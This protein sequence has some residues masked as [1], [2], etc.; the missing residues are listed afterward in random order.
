LAIKRQLKAAWK[1]GNVAKHS[2]EVEA[3]IKLP[4]KLIEENVESNRLF[5][6]FG[7]FCFQELI[8]PWCFV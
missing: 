3:E 8:V 7:S 6:G 2:P 1:F 4:A 5:L